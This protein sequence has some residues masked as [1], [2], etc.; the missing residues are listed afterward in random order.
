M[1]LNADRMNV[2]KLLLLV[3]VS[4]VIST[5]SGANTRVHVWEAVELNFEAQNSYENPHAEV[6]LW[7]RLKGPGFD[8][9]V[10]GFWDGSN[11]FR[12][13]LT[14]TKPGVWTWTSDSSQNDRFI[15]I[16]WTEKEKQ[17]NQNRRG[18]LRPTENGR[19]Y[20]YADGN[21]FGRGIRYGDFFQQP[22]THTNIESCLKRS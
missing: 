13:R 21:P 11:T 2:K 3:S 19:A 20:N 4:L 10:Y 8:K 15:T 5:G 1:S 7:V 6:E 18:F 16:P 22:L 14:G 9:K 12:V 17:S